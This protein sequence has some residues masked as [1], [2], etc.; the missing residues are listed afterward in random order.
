MFRYRYSKSGNSVL[1]IQDRPLDATFAASLDKVAG[2]AVKLDGSGNVVQAATGDTAI[3]GIMTGWDFAGQGVTPTTGKV[4]SNADA[5]FEADVVGGTPVVGGQYGIDGSSNVDVA[6]VTVKVVVCEKIV[7][8][9][10]YFSVLP[11]AL[12]L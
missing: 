2:Y 11:A 10:Y 5:V 4:L 9:K 7:N 3:A 12:S 8:G 6:D 1:P